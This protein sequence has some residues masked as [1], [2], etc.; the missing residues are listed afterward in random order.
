MAYL[1]TL[2]TPA[3]ELHFVSLSGMPKRYIVALFAMLGRAMLAQPSAVE[4]LGTFELQLE[5][6]AGL[7]GSIAFFVARNSHLY[8]VVCGA[9]G[10][11]A[12]QTDTEGIVQSTGSL[13]AERRVKSPIVQREKIPAGLLDAPRDAVSM[14]GPHRLQCLQ[15]H[16]TPA[17]PAKHRLC[18]PCVFTYCFAI[19]ITRYLLEYKRTIPH[20]GNFGRLYAGGSAMNV[21]LAVL[22]SGLGLAAS[23][24]PLLAHHSVP[25]EYDVSKTI[26]IQGVVTK[27][28]WMN[29]H[30]HFWVEVKNDDGTVSDWEMELPSPNALV[31]E[32]LKRDFIKQGDRVSADLWPD[33][34]GFRLAHTLT[35]TLPDGRVLNFPRD[36]TPGRG[37][38]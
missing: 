5:Q 36:W 27:I 35:L 38:L 13:G 22:V 18:R 29:P 23:V 19:G 21:K 31:N 15:H 9:N 26:T 6:R 11:L 17:C 28:E 16:Q 34:R 2:P 33:K 25:A 30:A 4:P 10:W 20:H 1:S 12:F 14:L 3:I 8:F 24:M 37:L 32:N 7:S